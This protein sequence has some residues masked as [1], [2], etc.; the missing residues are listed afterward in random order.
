MRYSIGVNKSAINKAII[1]FA[2]LRIC[3][4]ILVCSFHLPWLKC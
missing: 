3:G 2:G 4:Y 1:P